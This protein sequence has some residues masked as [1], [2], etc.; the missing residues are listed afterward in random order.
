MYQAMKSS[1]KNTAMICFDLKDVHLNIPIQ[2][3]KIYK[4][5]IFKKYPYNQTC[6]SCEMEQLKN[7]KRDGYTY[8][9]THIVVGEH[10]PYWTDELIF[11]RY[12][13]FMQK[14]Q[15]DEVIPRVFDIY[16]AH[17]TSQNRFALLGAIAGLLSNNK[18]QDKNFTE[19]NPN[20]QK[21]KT[22]FDK[23]GFK[24]DAKKEEPLI[25]PNTSHSTIEKLQLLNI[26]FWYLKKTCLY[27]VNKLSILPPILSIGVRTEEEK[28]KI[29]LVIPVGI[30]IV[31]DSRQPIKPWDL[32]AYVPVPVVT[33]LANMFGPSWKD[34]TN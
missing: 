6:L 20:F 12:F 15:W 25:V 31:V 4:H 17:P 1:Y 10:S 19:H 27:I 5:D 9:L 23:I 26:K 3:V 30:E 22:Y 32:N 8:Q 16:N 7:L 24:D 18:I 21:I 29:L 11:D 33:Y 34:L 13:I 14:N 2:G 28:R